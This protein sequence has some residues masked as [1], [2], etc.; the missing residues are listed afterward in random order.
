MLTLFVA[1]GIFIACL[2][3]FGL[4]IFTAE[5]RTKEIGIRKISAHGPRHCEAHALE[6][7]SASPVANV[8]AWP[9]AYYY[10]HRWL[11]GYAYRISPNP[12]YFLGRGRCGVTDLLGDCLPAHAGARAYQSRARAAL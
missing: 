2:G 7:F 10:L 6:D 8:I 3:L 11:E 9:I 4:T 1:L 5:R 12:I